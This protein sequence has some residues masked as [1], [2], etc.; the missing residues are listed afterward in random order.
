MSLILEYWPL[1]LAGVLGLVWLVRL[2]AKVM[3]S[4]RERKRDQEI[5]SKCAAKQDERTKSIYIA[6][7]DLTER[8]AAMEATLAAAAQRIGELVVRVD[9]I[10]DGG[11]GNV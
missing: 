4:G 8:V 10:K 7:A 6:L 5:E 11:G 2:E 9:R 1:I 3:A